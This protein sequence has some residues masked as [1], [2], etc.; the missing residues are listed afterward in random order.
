MIISFLPSQ[1]LI[2]VVRKVGVFKEQLE[3][4]FL[5]RA[6]RIKNTTDETIHLKKYVFDLRT[7]G[8]S[9]KQITYSEEILQEQSKALSD[10]AKR[11]LN[12]REGYREIFRNGTVHVLLGTEKVWDK[13]RL[14]TT[15]TLEPRQETGFMN[16]CFRIITTDAIDELVFVVF[17][18]EDRREKNAQISIPVVQ[19]GNK[20]KYIFPVK[21]AWRVTCNWDGPDSHRDAYSQEFAFDLDQLDRNMEV[22]LNQKRPNEEYPCYGKEVIAV[23]DGEVVD[24]FDQLPENPSS[25]SDLSKKQIIKFAQEYGYVHL[26]GGNQVV[27]KH[28]NG[29][30]SFYAHLIPGSLKVKKGDKVKRGQILGKVGNSGNSDGPHL[31]F[32]LMDG[33]DKSTARGLPCRFINIKNCEGDQVKLI[34]RDR[35]IIH[36]V[37]HES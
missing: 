16:E 8:K 5:L 4:D 11:F 14:S 3:S 21:G 7:K 35:S 27:L 25:C 29:E 1:Y 17:Y 22:V 15:T 2:N 20:N 26:S 37:N 9:R 23:A 24:S 33:P 12:E 34:D 31:H 10:F 19:Y 36:T 32:Q 6:I 28:S 13:D 30:Y 18:V